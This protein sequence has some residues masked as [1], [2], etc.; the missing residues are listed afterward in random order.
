MMLRTLWSRLRGDTAP[1]AHP[2]PADR[3]H[4]ARPFAPRLDAL[5]ARNTVPAYTQAELWQYSCLF[6]PDAV[7]YGSHTAARDLIDRKGLY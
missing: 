1:A 2:A 7:S 5:R 3:F 6:A 4:H